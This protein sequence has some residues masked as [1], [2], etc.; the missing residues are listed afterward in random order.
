LVIES[1]ARDGEVLIRKLK[2]WNN[3]WGFALQILE[4]DYLDEAL[5]DPERNITMGVQMDQWGRPTRY[6]LFKSHPGSINRKAQRGEY[7]VFPWDEILHIYRIERPGQTRGVPWMHASMAH[8]HHL[9]KYEEAELVAARV[10][11]AKMWFYVRPS[12]VFA[13]IP[14]D[15]KDS[16]GTLLKDAEPGTGEQLPPGYDVR[17]FEPEHPNATFPDFVKSNLR[18]AAAGLGVSYNSLAN[19]LESVNYSS[20]RAGSLEERDGWRT[21]QGWFVRSFCEPVFK[22]WL[23]WSMVKGA[24]SLP[25]R[26]YE[27]FMAPTWRP[28]GWDWIDPEKDIEAARLAILSGFDT[29]TKIVAMRGE[30]FEDILEQRKEEAE[31]EAEY[32]V[33]TKLEKESQA[34]AG[35]DAE[36][37]KKSKE[38]V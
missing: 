9:E 10:G 31:L 28:R 33:E 26:K 12:D 3:D 4:A 23:Y 27:Q 17:T 6:H 18:G 38:E 14:G 19:D 15:A 35:A 5:N 22:E 34:G 36:K 29:K 11:A 25:V 21:L 13:D 7:Q 32:G 2:G 8:L 30:E 37:N 24:I 1:V 16:D 20:Y